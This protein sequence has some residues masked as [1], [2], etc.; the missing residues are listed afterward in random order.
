MGCLVIQFVILS[1]AR[2][3]QTLYFVQGGKGGLSFWGVS[4]SPEPFAPLVILT[5]NEVKGDKIEP[6]L[7]KNP[8]R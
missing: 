8:K 3:P 1:E 5:L 2:N 6:Q 7:M 4:Q